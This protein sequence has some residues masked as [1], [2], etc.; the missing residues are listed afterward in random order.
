MFVGVTHDETFGPLIACGA[1]GTLVELFKDVPVGLTLLTEQ[2]ADRDCL[3]TEDI[4]DSRRLQRRAE[5]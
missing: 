4:P 1:G 2:D 3:F 5:V